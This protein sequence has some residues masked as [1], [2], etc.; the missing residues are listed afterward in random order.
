MRSLS[1]KNT[2]K[3]VNTRSTSTTVCVR[4]SRNHGVKINKFITYGFAVNIAP[5]ASLWPSRIVIF[6]LTEVVVTT[7]GVAVKCVS[8]II[9]TP[10]MKSVATRV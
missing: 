2:S 9:I 3:I 1:I 10:K 4:V 8:S 7:R 6:A 5:A